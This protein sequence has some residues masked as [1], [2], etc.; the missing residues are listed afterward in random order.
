VLYQIHELNQR[1]FSPAI[2]FAEIGA[3]AF[4][5][6][7]S[8]LSWLPG[9]SYVA[10]GCE[11][12]Y[13]LGKI[14][15]K[16]KFGIDDAE[17]HGAHVAVHE[18]TVSDKPFCRL[19]RFQRHS[20]DAAL[21]AQLDA[22]PTVLVV[23]PLS[24]HHATLLRD[25]VRALLSSHDVYITDWINA[26]EVPVERGP[27]SL[28]DYVHYVQDFMRQLGPSRLHVLAVC[29]PS[30][31]VLAAAALMA[32]GGEPQP[33]SLILMGGPVDTRNAPT[34]VTQFANS[35]SV[36]WFDRFLIDEVPVGYR[37]RGRRVYPGF[38]QY[39][40]FMA[41]N[42]TRHM[43]SRWQFFQHLVEGDLQSA[44]EHRR[45]Y[46][47]YNAVMDLA[48]EYYLD[49]ITVVFHEHLLPLGRWFIDDRRVAPEVITRPALLTIEGARD[50]IS[51]L[52]ATRAALDLCAGIPG[53]RKRH[54]TVE[55]G[56][57]YGIFS[58]R[59]WRQVVYPQVR[60]FIAAARQ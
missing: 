35:H 48:A 22:D 10:A 49:C 2:D 20:D 54:I 55:D 38:L 53:D 36:A 47:E 51:G 41:M 18:Q 45:F 6:P 50:D 17:A 30:V 58:G 15:D 23:A 60:D 56:G 26:R 9:A 44:E 33:Q 27:F 52:G 8:P 5:A 29:Q 21:S 25:T 46:D 11:V 12:L 59:K 43:R 3:R 37:G 7:A 31:P 16:P 24:G 28:A 13:R 32:A 1:L 40:G 4:S 19:Q 42:P 14:Y 34:Q 57:H 39:A